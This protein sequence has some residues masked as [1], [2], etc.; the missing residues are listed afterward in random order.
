MLTGALFIAVGMIAI[1]AATRLRARV[2]LP[3]T[4]IAEAPDA[5]IVRIKGR[6]SSDTS[7]RAPYSQLPC[8]FYQL[9]LRCGQ[10]NREVHYELSDGCDFTVTDATGT[11]VV[12]R[13]RAQIEALAVDG[14]ATRVSRLSERAR[15]VIEAHGWQLPEIASVSLAE[16]VIGVGDIVEVAGV[17]TREPGVIEGGERGFRDAPPMQLVFASD[18]YVIGRSRSRP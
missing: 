2:S 18:V 10:F 17:P 12:L 8:V 14:E 6:V 15:E 4:T 1:A 5:T 7:L 16:S 13:E 9:E 11:A 3:I